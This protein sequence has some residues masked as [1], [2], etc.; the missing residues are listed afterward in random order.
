[1]E[2]TFEFKVNNDIPVGLGHE[3]NSNLHQENIN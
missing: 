2:T 1:M 3:E